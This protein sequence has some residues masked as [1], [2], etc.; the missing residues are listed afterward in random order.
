MKSR[1]LIL[2]LLLTII[3]NTYVFSQFVPDEPKMIQYFDKNKQLEKIIIIDVLKNKKNTDWI[4]DNNG[5][6]IEYSKYIYDNKNRLI[7]RKVF[8]KS[9]KLMQEYSYKYDSRNRKTKGEIFISETAERIIIQNK[10]RGKVLMES[11]IKE[12]GRKS[13]STKYIYDLEKGL[14]SG[15]EIYTYE[16]GQKLDYKEIIAYDET[17]NYRIINVQRLN[18]EDKVI[19]YDEYFYNDQMEN[20]IMQII[21]SDKYSEELLPTTITMPNKYSD[22][23]FALYIFVLVGSSGDSITIRPFLYTSYKSEGSGY[24]RIP[25]LNSWKLDNNTLFP[26]DGEL[27]ISVSQGT[28]AKLTNEILKT[29]AEFSVQ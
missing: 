20:E 10:Y 5:E 9:N 8:D 6:I 28:N 26:I 13:K 7:S 23:A 16:S 29:S 25:F 3:P 4:L 2:I 12:K 22:R 11:T 18:A 17:R 15:K 27:R 1:I 24:H 21:P 19:G 14:L